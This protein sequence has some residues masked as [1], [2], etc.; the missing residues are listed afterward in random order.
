[1]KTVLAVVSVLILLV[2]IGTLVQERQWHSHLEAEQQASLAAAARE[3]RV[4]DF[5]DATGRFARWC[6]GIWARF[7]GARIE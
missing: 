1:M 5:L 7:T 2:L 6:P 4:N 3:K